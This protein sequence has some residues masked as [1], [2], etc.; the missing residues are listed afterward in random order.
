M[1]LEWK[2]SLRFPIFVSF[3]HCFLET[4]FFSFYFLDWSSSFLLDEGNWRER[5]VK[6]GKQKNWVVLLLS[7]D[8]PDLLFLFETFFVCC[9]WTVQTKQSNLWGIQ[10]SSF[11]LFKKVFTQNRKCFNVPRTLIPSKK[12]KTHFILCFSITAIY[13]LTKSS[14]S[15]TGLHQI[16]N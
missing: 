14:R 11:E 3:S 15:Q 6:H 10:S 4:T 16:P 2:P 12:V 13:S 9:S 7:I 5:G 8:F 1:S